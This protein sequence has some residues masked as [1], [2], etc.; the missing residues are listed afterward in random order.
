[1]FLKIAAE[2]YKDEW[3][4]IPY[5]SN[6]P[7]FHMGD[8]RYDDYSEEKMKYFESISDFHKISYKLKDGKQPSASSIYQHIIDE[9]KTPHK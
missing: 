6:Q 5:M 1:M 8:A 3:E 4:K 7:P 2:T 9:Y